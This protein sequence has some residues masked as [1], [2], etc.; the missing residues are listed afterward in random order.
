MKNLNM[1]FYTDIIKQCYEK[2]NIVIQ[3]NLLKNNKQNV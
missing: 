2:Y 1:W 3:N